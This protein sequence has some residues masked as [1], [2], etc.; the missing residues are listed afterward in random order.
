MNVC[1]S[2]AD[3]VPP[4]ALIYLYH[5][6]PSLQ[7][8]EFLQAQLQKCVVTDETYA[9]EVCKAI[10]NMHV[11]NMERQIPLAVPPAWIACTGV[12]LPSEDEAAFPSLGPLYVAVDQDHTSSSLA[13]AQLTY[14]LKVRQSNYFTALILENASDKSEPKLNR[15]QHIF[16][17]FAESCSFQTTEDFF[18]HTVVK[19]HLSGVLTIFAGDLPPYEAMS[20]VLADMGNDLIRPFIDT[21]LVEQLRNRISDATADDVVLF[22]LL[23]VLAT[24]ME[25]ATSLLPLYN[26]DL[27]HRA[28]ES[29]VLP[30]IVV[31]FPI[32]CLNGA[33]DA[34]GYTQ[35]D[36]LVVANGYGAVAAFEHWV[37]A[38]K[39]TLPNVHQAMTRAHIPA[40]NTLAKYARN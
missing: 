24:E 35:G 14:L 29:A 28:D 12:K 31:D 40:G 17:N 30:F 26:S 15:A 5:Q 2:L 33:R 13:S 37:G 16:L 4:S 34:Y 1:L 18:L 8:A 38:N 7:A 20:D 19:M 3:A 21:P 27:L 39:E 36:T 25:Q 23:C 9:R 10:A 11:S 22:L 32:K 6:E